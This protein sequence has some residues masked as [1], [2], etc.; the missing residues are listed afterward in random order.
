MQF[1]QDK[2]TV[3]SQEAIAAAQRLAVSGAH[4]E[5]TGLHLLAALLA[6]KDGVIA[7]LLDAIHAGERAA[8]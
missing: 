7:P 5:L 3:K 8:R 4:P 2:L 6:E 1:S